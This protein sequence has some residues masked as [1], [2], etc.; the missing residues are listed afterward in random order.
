MNH[1]W[2]THEP[3]ITQIHGALKGETG[4]YSAHLYR[5]LCEG[6]MGLRWAGFAVPGWNCS[7]G[8]DACAGAADRRD[9]YIA[10]VDPRAFGAF[11]E[12]AI[13]SG[14]FSQLP[15]LYQDHTGSALAREYARI[16]GSHT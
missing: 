12:A 13:G 2:P 10:R 5:H 4:R 11:V 1:S 14:S 15:S 3:L 7:A 9:L 6:Q 8:G 16:V